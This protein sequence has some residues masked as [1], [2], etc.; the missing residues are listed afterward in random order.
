VYPLFS[1]GGAQPLEGGQRKVLVLLEGATRIPNATIPHLAGHA[2]TIT[3]DLETAKDRA[4]GVIVAQGSRYGGFTLYL[5]DGHVVYEV[6]AFGN[7]T[8]RLI[9]RSSLKPGKAH[10]VLEVNPEGPA[11]AQ[12]RPGTATLAINGVAQGKETFT[13]LNGSSY[14]ETL[15]VGSD[16]GSSVSTAYRSPD[17]FRGK[18][19]YLKVEIR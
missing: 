4:D 11:G 15:D 12:V 9:S 17:V 16:L 8:G 3:A 6:N 7:R 5:Q 13:N 10:V 14:T 18:I 1:P 2:Y 19:D